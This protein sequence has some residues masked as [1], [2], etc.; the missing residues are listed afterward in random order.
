VNALTGAIGVV[1][2][3]RSRSCCNYIDSLGSGLVK[4]S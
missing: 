3:G 4:D 1:K 2:Y